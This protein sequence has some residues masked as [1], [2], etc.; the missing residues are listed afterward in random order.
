MSDD[1]AIRVENVSKKYSKSLKRSMLYGIMDIGRNALRMSSNSGRL[2]KREF[3]A[4]K[5]VSFELK[6]GETLGIIGPNGSGKTTMLKM[7][8]G[9]FWPD[10]GK[11]S[12]RGKVGALIAVGAGFHPLLTGRENIFLNGAILGLSKKQITARFDEIIEFADIGD[13]INT[14]VKYYSSGMFVRLGFAVAVHCDPDIL[15]VDEV[16]SVGDMEFQK[17]CAAKIQAIRERTSTI[18]VSH[19]LRHI[20]RICDRALLIFNGET[21]RIG[22]VNDVVQTY[23]NKTI[24]FSDSS[25]SVTVLKSLDAIRSVDVTLLD[26]HSIAGRKLEFEH[27]A[28]IRIGLESKEEFPNALCAL[29]VFSPEGALITVI[30]SEEFPFDLQKGTNKL[31]CRIKE[32]R[33]VPGTYSMKLKL[34]S[35][36]GPILAEVD[37]GTF[38]VLE[39]PGPR[40]P[41]S[42][43]YREK[44]NWTLC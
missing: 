34:S 37:A 10:E 15:L 9:I 5:N 28:A 44:A 33:M 22:T 40:R 25:E 26:H 1:I 7:L 19:N 16:L 14:P 36:L 18:F 42:G 31:E 6:R 32:L 3:W 29:S 4:V 21:E 30:N 23:I 8:N 35:K 11:I 17:K 12:I 43:S 24:S 39:S 27:P 2:R 38:E 20:F 13:F 41:M